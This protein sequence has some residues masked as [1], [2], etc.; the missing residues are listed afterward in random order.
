LRLLK[1]PTSRLVW[2]VK[3]QLLR[4]ATVMCAVSVV[5][6]LGG[7]GTVGAMAARDQMERRNE[8]DLKNGKSNG[9]A[10]TASDATRSTGISGEEYRCGAPAWRLLIAG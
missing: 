6:L 4:S 3:K 8:A 7:C 1:I 10:N 2:P 5:M 9:R